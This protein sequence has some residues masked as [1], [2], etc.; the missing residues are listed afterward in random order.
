MATVLPAAQHFAEKVHA[1]T[2]PWRDRPNTRVRDLV[3][4][5]LLINTG[6]LEPTTTV[7]A[8]RLTFD[9]RA[10]HPLPAALP[11]PPTEWAIPFAALAVEVALAE[12]TVDAAFA[13]A[14]I[15]F[16]ALPLEG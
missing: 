14:S 7:A 13:R 9:R 11:P 6:L 2:F 10:T 3:D 4:L 16:A 8:L 12:R 1:Y 5:A 15:F